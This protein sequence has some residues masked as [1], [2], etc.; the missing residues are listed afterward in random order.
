[1]IVHSTKFEGG[2]SLEQLENERGE[3]YYRACTG[4]IC[5]YA[6]DEYIARMYLEGMGWDPT[7]P[8][9]DQSTPQSQPPA[10]DPRNPAPETTPASPDLPSE[11]CTTDTR[12]SGSSDWCGRLYF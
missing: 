12:V 10:A 7:Q 5:R 2:F 3:I 6:E 8:E 4:S 11:H 9:L 1:M